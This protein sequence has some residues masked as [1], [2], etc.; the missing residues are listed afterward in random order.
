MGEGLDR[1]GACL[2]FWLRG[3]GLNR[4]ESYEGQGFYGDIF[5]SDACSHKVPKAKDVTPQ[6]L[7]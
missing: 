3:E 1:E 2:K 7:I 6:C 5:G 4:E